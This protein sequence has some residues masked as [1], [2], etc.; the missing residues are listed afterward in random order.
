VPSL[1][2]L[3]LST[4]C[5]SEP[6][7]DA[8]IIRP[9]RY[10]EVFAT[11][12]GRTRSFS[13]TAQAGLETRLSFKVGGTIQQLDLEIGDRVNAG[14]TIARLDPTDY[15]LSVRDTEA[16]L[17]RYQAESRQALADYERVRSLYE[18]D[19]ASRADLDASRAASEAKSAGVGSAEQKLA[20]ARLNVE[21]TTLKAPVAGAISDV[22]VEV[23]ENVNAGQ[24]I[25]VLTS[26]QRSEVTVTIPE[27]L[28][29]AVREGDAV[30]VSLD[31][32]AGREFGATVT[33]VG[34][35]AAR[36]GAAFPVT[37]R[38]ND[39]TD[40]VRPG[41]AAEV[42]FRFAATGPERIYVPASSVLE[43]REGRY[44]F[45]VERTDPGFG[46]TRRR[47]VEVGDITANG[48]VIRA[49]LEDGDLLVTAG[50]TKIQDGMRVRLPLPVP[51][52]AS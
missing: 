36:T 24:V 37:A 35:T 43:D 9:V 52:P 12:A 44:A 20:M 3:L 30:R 5:A 27:A 39:E 46:V 51:Q 19:N 13:G 2:A 1:A 16:A 42:E 23:N 50:V 26:G 40:D 32:L 25:A 7:D 48:L 17:S 45:V 38:L 47:A 15:Q 49:G 21:Y 8:P 11:G 4:A 14:Q 29:G 6:A 22:A 28:I 10:Q 33:E 18:N 41:M 34:V 31:A